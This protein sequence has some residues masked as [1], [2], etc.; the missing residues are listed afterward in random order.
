MVRVIRPE[1]ALAVLACVSIV[2][3]VLVFF[4]LRRTQALELKLLVL[5]LVTAL[6]AVWCGQ[7][8]VQ[9]A[10]TVQM[11]PGQGSGV[12]YG[13][14]VAGTLGRIAILLVLGA[15]AVAI[16]NQCNSPVTSPSR[17][18]AIREHKN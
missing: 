5:G 11:G 15:I 8:G 10:T 6:L 1:D 3:L 9:G 4:I 18:E 7:S 12:F 14:D 16:L 13:G 17:E 2:Y